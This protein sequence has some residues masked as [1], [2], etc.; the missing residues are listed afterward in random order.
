[1]CHQGH[2]LRASRGDTSVLSF[3]DTIYFLLREPRAADGV[4]HDRFRSPEAAARPGPRP[5]DQPDRAGRD[6]RSDRRPGRRRDEWQRRPASFADVRDCSGRAPFGADRDRPPARPD[7][8]EPGWPRARHRDGACRAAPAGPRGRS[9]R[10]ERAARGP[11]VSGR[12]PD[13]RRPDRLVE[14]RRRIGRSGSRV[15]AASKRGGLA[16]RSR[17]SPAPW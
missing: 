10:G 3:A 17:V 2:S 6:G 13:R 4:V 7:G 8:A 14:W 1:M 12:Q 9:D 5:R 16:D 11:D 15:H